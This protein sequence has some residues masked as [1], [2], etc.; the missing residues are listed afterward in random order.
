MVWAAGIFLMPSDCLPTEDLE[1]FYHL[2]G[3]SAVCL[4]K[5]PVLE[6]SRV[7]RKGGKEERIVNKGAAEVRAGRV[8]NPAVA[9]R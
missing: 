1:F 7:I 5:H 3:Q 2:P 8:G 4:Q 9:T 6:N